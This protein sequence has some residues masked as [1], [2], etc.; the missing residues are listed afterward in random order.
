MF[1]L[2]DTD[3]VLRPHC[4][5][6]LQSLGHGNINA[7]AS[8]LGGS[9]SR[10]SSSSL[11]DQCLVEQRYV[12]GAQLRTLIYNQV[13]HSAASVHTTV[14]LARLMIGPCWAR[15]QQRSGPERVVCVPSRNGRRRV[16]EVPGLP[17][18]SR[19]WPSVGGWQATPAT[20]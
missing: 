3:E 15:W 9:Y 13:G 2:N 20:C 16:G 7:P 5:K 11:M 4:T 8:I 1:S 10:L 17:A 6:L 19:C 14:P 12:R 18:S